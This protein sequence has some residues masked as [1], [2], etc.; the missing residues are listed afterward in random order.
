MSTLRKKSWR[1]YLGILRIL[2]HDDSNIMVL[3]HLNKMNNWNRMI[4]HR[5][6]TVFRLEHMYSW[7]GGLFIRWEN[8][9][10]VLRKTKP[11][12]CLL[13]KWVLAPNRLKTYFQS[14]HEANRKKLY[15]WIMRPMCGK[16]FLK[17]Q[18]AQTVRGNEI[19]LMLL[20]LSFL[21]PA[22]AVK[23]AGPRNHPSVLCANLVALQSG[24]LCWWVN[25]AETRASPQLC[26]SE[27]L[28]KCSPTLSLPRRLRKL[29]IQ[30][31]HVWGNA[32]FQ[33]QLIPHPP[34][35]SLTSILH[36]GAVQKLFTF[37]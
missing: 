23:G 24:P 37:L 17:M 11:N 32:Q 4:E 33:A 6:T 1:E 9:L 20:R 22:P 12:P 14:Y 5:G 21:L 28:C 34:L 13:H 2:S 3:A 16:G 15:M 25:C 29:P 36:A 7:E 27:T 30:P 19:C 8:L 10:T 35:D 18:N 31:L 26:L